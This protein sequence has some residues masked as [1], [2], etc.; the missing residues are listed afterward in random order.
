MNANCYKII[1]SKH[2]GTLVAVGEHTTSTGKA[3]SG[4]ACRGVA[5]PTSFGDAMVDGFVGVLRLAFA[6]VALAC[7]T[8]SATQ[9]QSNLGVV[10]ATALPQGA[11]VNTGT[12]NISTLGANMAITQTTDKAS[13]NWQSFNV[14]TGASVNITQPSAS[15]VL[16]NRVVGNDPSQILGKL[17]ANGQLILLNPNGIVF[18]KDGSV[19][20][21]S[22]TASTFGLSDADFM[23][24]FYKYNRNGSTAAVVNQGTIE[25]S[26]GGF[27]ALI[28]ATVTNEGTIRAPQGDVMLV[29][30]ETVTLPASVG[31]SGTS[32]TNNTVSVRMSKRVR[33]EL[34]PAAINT[35]V[36]NTESG[37]IVTE[38]GQ[39]LLQAAALSTAVA[40]VTHSGSIDTSAPQAG[41]VT[42][43]AE[44]GIIKV[45]GSITANSSGS[46]GQGQQRKGGDIIIGRDEE[47]GALAKFTDVSGAKLESQHGFVETSGEYLKTD[48]ISVKAKEWL[49]DPSDIT[50][51]SSADSNVTGVSP[52]DITPNGATGTSSVV[53]VSTIQTAI[54]AGTNVTIKTTNASNTTGSGNITIAN[55]LTFNNSGPTDATLSLIADNGITQNAAASITTNVASAK[56]VN[57]NMTA[58]GNYQGSSTAHASSA[59]IELRSTINTNG[60]VTLDG[61]NNNTGAGSGVKFVGGSG[62]TAASY[63]INGNK[64]GTATNSYGVLFGTGSSSLVSTGTS[65][66]NGISNGSTGAFAVGLMVDNGATLTLDAGAGSLVAK[67][68]NPNATYQTGVRIGNSSIA[69]ITTKGNVTLGAKEDNSNFSLRSGVVTADS[70]SLTILGQSSYTSGISFF[71]GTSSIKS[72]NGASI[73]LNGAAT[74]GTSYGVVLNNTSIDAG[75]TGDVSITGTSVGNHGIYNPWTGSGA[76]N[77]KVLGRNISINGT[78]SGTNTSGFYSFIGSSAG[79]IITAAGDISI[80]GTANGTGT[81]SGLYYST[82]NWQTY[83]NSYTAGGSIALSGTNTSATN[84]AEAVRLFGVQAQTT[85]AGNISVNASTQNAGV[86]A[87]TIYS[88]GALANGYQ[89]G[90]T[91]L[92]S[93]SGDVKIQTNQGG[94]IL[95]DGVPNSVTSTTISGRN[96]SID[97]TGGTIDATTGVIGKGLGVS[98]SGNSGINIRDARAITATG[99]INLYGVGTSGSGVEILGAAALSAANIT[100]NGEN[101]GAGGAAINISNASSTLTA[102]AATTLTASGTGSGTSLVAA[103]N[104]S[105]GTQ[106][107]VTTPAAGNISGVISGTG[108]LLKMGAGQTKLTAYNGTTYGTNTFSGG[109]TISQGT[110][111]LG[112]GNGSYNKTA[113]AGVITLGDANTGNNNVALLIDKGKDAGQAALSRGITVSNNGTGTATIGAAAFAAGTGWT[114]INSTISLNR[115]VIFTDATSDRLGLDGNISGTGNITVAGTNSRITM[116]ST[117]TFTG[118][119]TVAS[120]NQ[121]EAGVAN[122]FSSTTNMDVNG[123]FNKNG[124]DQTINSLTGA[125]TGQVTSSGTLTIGAN[126]GGGTYAGVISNA[127]NL[128]K[129]GTGT[130]ILTGNNG[131]TGTTTINAGTLQIGNGSTTGAIGS[132]TIT[133]NAA[134]VFNRSD[135]TLVV[136]AKISGTGNVTQAGTGTTTLSA[137]N[138]WSGTTTISAGT[139][140]IGNGSTTGTLGTSTTVTNN[141]T[142]AFKRSDNIFVGQKITGTGGLTQAGNGTMTLIDS[143]V[144]NGVNDYSGVTTINAG[145]TL[146]V[147]NGT[148]VGNLGSGTITDNGKLVINHSD[149]VA[150]SKIISGSGVLEQ[151]G[152]GTTTLTAINSYTGGTNVTAGILQ[153]GDGTN[154]GQIGANTVNISTAATLNFNV[155]SASSANYS[156]TNTFTGTGTLKKSGTGTLTWGSAVGVFAMTG[157]LID[158]QG[159][160]FVGSN[161]GNEVWT[162]NKASLNIATG[163]SLQGV[164]GNIIVDA[165][166][167]NGTLSSGYTGYLY[168]LTVGVNGGSGTFSGVIQDANAQAAKLTKLG[169]GTQILTGTNTYT[170]TTTISGGTL[171][172]GNGGTTGT[173]G[174]GAI[175]DNA[176]LIINRDASADV[177]IGGNISGTGTLTQSGAGKTILTGTNS[178]Q[179]TT[180]IDAGSLQVGNGGATGT[181]G[182]GSVI[183]S[184]AL[185]FKRDATTDLTV[186]SAISGI[187]TLSQIGAG[188]TVLTGSNSY[189]GTTTISSGTLQVGS[190]GATGTLGSGAV[191]D[192]AALIFN[193]DTTSGLAVANAITGTGTLTQSGTGKTILSAQ[194]GYSGT[195]AVSGGTLQIGNGGTTGNLGSTT[196]VTLSNNA[197]LTFS[198]SNTTTIDKAISGNGNVSADITGGDLALASAISLT[199]SNTINLTASGSITETAGSLAATNLYMTATG[200]SIGT[201][202]QRIQTNVNSLSLSSAGDQFVTETNGVTVASRTTNNGSID[203]ATTTGTLTV[204]AA[205]SVSGISANGTGNVTL[206]GTADGSNAGLVL[207]QNISGTTLSL[208]GTATGTGDGIRASGTTLTSLGSTTL[209]G[210]SAGVGAGVSLNG[211]TVNNNSTS[212]I[213]RIEAL[214]GNL[215][216]QA[217]STNVINNAAMAGGVE[218]K[219]STGSV[220]VPMVV[221]AGTGDIVVAAG[222]ATAAGTGTGGQVLTIA[223]NTLTQTNGTPG[224]TYVYT[225]QAS[226]TGVLSNLSTDFANLYYEGTSHAVNAGFNTTFDSNHANDLSAPTGGSVSSAQVFF[227]STTKPG[228]SLTLNNAQKSYGDVDPSLTSSNGATLTNAVAG[229]G[230]SNTFAVTASDVIAGLAGT[231]ATGE[232]VGTYAYTLSGSTF[233]TTLTAQPNLVIGQRDISLSTLI[234]DNKIYDGTTAAHISGATFNTVNGETLGL[235]GA[236][237]FDTKNAGT[238]KTV[239]VDNIGTLSASDGI[240]Y[241]GKWSNYRLTTTGN[242]TTHAN[243]SQN[244]TAHVVLTANSDNSKVYNGT[245]QNITG[246]G[247]AGLV[248]DDATNTAAAVA[249]IAAGVSGKNAGSYTSTFTGSN[250]DLANNYANIT[251]NDGT[252]TIAQ[253][254]T[255][256]VVLTAN[257]DTS[258]V[259][260]GTTQNVTGFGVVGLVGDDAANATNTAAAVAGITAGASG[261]NAVSYTSTFTGSNADLANNY[262]NITKATGTLTIAQKDVTLASITAANKTYDG[263]DIATITAGLIATG[264]GTE[265]LAVSGRGTFSNKNADT[266]KTVTVADVTTLT[267]TNGTGDWTNYRLTTTGSQTTAAD[268]LKK[269]L[270]ISATATDK[271]YDATKSATTSL[272]SNDV[273]L[274]DTVTLDKTSATFDNKNVGQ[275]KTVHVAGLSISGTSAGNYNLTNTSTT[276]TAAIGQALLTVTASQVT[277]EYDGLTTATGTGTFSALAG[278]VVNNAGVQVFA[279]KDAGASNKIVQANGV[280][281]KDALTGADVTFNYNIQ[282]VNNTT[283]TITPAPLTIK[284][285]DTAMFVTQDARTA[286]GQGFSYST[287]KNGETAA[288]ALSGGALTAAD[289]IYT[290]ASNFPTAGSYTSVYGLAT[291]PTSVNGNYAITVQTGNLT[292]TPADKLLIT[293]ASQSDAYGNRTAANAGNAAAQS[294]S[295][296]Y[297]L[298][299]TNCNGANL[300]DLTT[301]QL[302]ANQWKAADNTGSFVVFDTTATGTS[303]STGGFLKAGNYVFNTTE[304]APL[305]LPNGNFTGRATNVGVLT[306]TPLAVTLGADSITKTYDGNT[307]ITGTAVR[308]T[309]SALGDI[310][311]ATASTGNFASK[312]VANGIAVSLSNLGLTGADAANYAL[313]TNALSGT[314]AITPKNLTANYTAAD[315][316][317]NANTTA[318]VTGGSSDIVSGD[319]VVFANTSANFDNKNAGTQKTVSVAGI[320]ISGASAGNYTLTSANAS[321]TANIIPKNLQANFTAANKTYDGNTL[322]NVTGSSNDIIAGDSVTIAATSANF[323]NASVGTAKPVSI[324]GIR[325][326]GTDGDNYALQNSSATAVADITTASSSGTNNSSSSNSGTSN[327]SS[328]SNVNPPKPIIPDDNSSS[329][330]GKGSGD[331]RSAQ[332]P[333]LLLPNNNAN[334]ADSCTASNLEACVCEEQD[335]TVVPKIAICYQPKKTVS[336]QAS[337]SRS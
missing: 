15:S 285:N 220:T 280:T 70:G 104:I 140:Q 1:F 232:D 37:V 193:R 71:D 283:S 306:I 103:S 105:V 122:I 151:S 267:K 56:L 60:R 31:N 201:A 247:V 163:A 225:G 107:K 29:A 113:G 297:C 190:G 168:G 282:Y 177:T 49:L 76:Y 23:D 261:K 119:V 188:K 184:T 115:D 217:S 85:G 50:I 335:P 294:V 320:S 196:G 211:I 51:S 312:N 139:L 208:T 147:G 228:F 150:L 326:G 331:G 172:V 38:G 289:R 45:D 255:A 123:T 260:N 6:S 43:L 84:T 68:S 157:G 263:N 231:R 233:N 67:G 164:E 92:V 53:N 149:A 278:D 183:N 143:A 272:L 130:Q 224:K 180:T 83:V 74:A 321:T 125:S 241:T 244:T 13:I 239:T 48:G 82:T 52:A 332:N 212:G 197:N 226:S 310:V 44:G 77:M 165:L 118:N 100:I 132:G 287:F 315:K 194:N 87:I 309:N 36:N 152:S 47:T 78:T 219:A 259:Y 240:G 72:N 249:G 33:L 204:G 142:L 121:L 91:S 308:T 34:D 274:G 269:D 254:T 167:G 189:Q 101:T 227:R 218:L 242:Q 69:T 245:T 209:T 145:G 62:I 73:T 4:Q 66:I 316:T 57:I 169:A 250:A 64:L 323:N 81:G 98:A 102:T 192:N 202:G 93:T 207:N 39:V 216:T 330:D 136:S 270:T 203:V 170:G 311:N 175:V 337:R 79:N 135:A 187:G 21:S 221:N 46:D 26:A 129:N 22:F 322:A 20:A 303:Y 243:I 266:G 288:M 256:N 213:T 154:N 236:A 16:L 334:T 199:G 314:G 185:I 246:F 32:S 138:D 148:T 258:K 264:V 276:T 94:I 25:T 200:G 238:G 324:A 210:S 131:Y 275:S 181:L 59:G 317:Y 28:G 223:G 7:M 24:G 146:Q 63:A 319:T 65:S 214:I 318:S 291:T 307:G 155:K 161:S 120:G 252:L 27:V 153:I 2:L 279:T 30:A 3:A 229:I 186:N 305:S 116:G 126:D 173:L 174:S 295:A 95:N 265:T 234:A 195:T 230:G 156:T 42:V 166:T 262:A 301:T 112:N 17:S 89:G 253:N 54:N 106:L 90:A 88:A 205:N 19:A 5:H 298:S 35:A 336:T 333:Y 55:A 273:L 133:D 114:I 124:L 292:V 9:A 215:D 58:S 109:T 300:V 86:N 182:S 176:S 286:L 159:G 171:Q 41:A 160:T 11:S 328:S 111:L 251:K 257:S 277:K 235:S 134:L 99:N 302:A 327:S 75:T 268:I 137:D 293:I 97:N 127:T 144:L 329:K 14:G 96:V 162:N 179:G 325:L 206:S 40:S 141:G 61:T 281:L 12:A 248:G 296:Q 158:V 237:V 271:V 108:A 8:L 117:K 304:I 110:L 198:K 284:V 10:A 128:V 18:G 222:T 191:V 313:A 290:G 80:T 178:Y 299:P